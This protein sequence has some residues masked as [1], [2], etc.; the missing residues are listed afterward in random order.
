MTSLSSRYVRWRSDLDRERAAWDK[1]REAKERQR[2]AALRGDVTR[3]PDGS[4]P[5][6]MQEEDS[7][8]SVAS[9]SSSTAPSPLEVNNPLSLSDKNP[10]HSYFASLT[11]LDQIKV[12]LQRAFPE[13][14][15]LRSDQVQRRLVRV[16]FVWSLLKENENVGYRQGMH[17]IAAI[18]L[19]VRNEEQE[20]TDKDVEADTFVLFEMIMKRAK[21]WYEWRNVT[22]VSELPSYLE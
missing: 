22:K 11:M 14:D 7:L 10:W 21:D 18:C 19:L 4:Y 5:T 17:E 15:R 8:S 12:D 9:T 13:D 2:Y 1:S 6:E 20:Q 16:L 3:A